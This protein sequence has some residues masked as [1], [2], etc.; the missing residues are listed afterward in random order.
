M[1]AFLLVVTVA[2]LMNI[3]QSKVYHTFG[4]E[5]LIFREEYLTDNL[6]SKEEDEKETGSSSQTCC[7][8]KSFQST[9]HLYKPGTSAPRQFKIFVDAANSR[10]ATTDG[11]VRKVIS[12]TPC[13]CT[14]TTIMVPR[15]LC[16]Q[17]ILLNVSFDDL[18]DR[19]IP[20]KA[21]N[22]GTVKMGKDGLSQSSMIVQQWG[23]S[24]GNTHVRK[25]VTASGCFPVAEITTRT[26]GPCQSE[27]VNA[28]YFDMA[29]PVKDPRVFAI[30]P[31]CRRVVEEV[32]AGSDEKLESIPFYLRFK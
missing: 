5:R 2:V 12:C 32:E 10:L 27:L 11:Q 7:Y 26:A 13:F 30:P 24:S 31:Y 20:Q 25:L 18:Y 28:Y 17:L 15:K 29:S 4:L 6:E 19:C 14:H 1:K 22:L 9:M 3:V 23:F 16:Q 8:P 21:I